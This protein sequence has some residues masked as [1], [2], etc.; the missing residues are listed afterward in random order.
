[1]KTLQVTAYLD[2]ILEK[3][4]CSPGS[5]ILDCGSLKV[6]RLKK[7]R[8]VFGNFT[9]LKPLGNELTIE[10]T[11]YKKQGGEY[12]LLPYKIRKPVF[13]LAKEDTYVYEDLCNYTNFELPPPCPFPAKTYFINGYTPSL[14]EFPHAII[15]SGDYRSYASYVIEGKEKAWMKVWASIIQL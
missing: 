11:A 14:K 4:E 5:E 2:V 13:D 6:K 1:M 3:V 8:L 15:P 9:F 7:Q 12:R 10:I